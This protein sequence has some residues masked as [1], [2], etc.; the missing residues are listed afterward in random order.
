M[1]MML[2][3][4]EA[5]EAVKRRCPAETKNVTDIILHRKLKI[6]G[7]CTTTFSH[8]RPSLYRSTYTRR[9]LLRSVLNEVNVLIRTFDCLYTG[10][11][12]TTAFA[13]E[14]DCLDTGKLRTTTKRSEALS[15]RYASL[16]SVLRCQKHR[17]YPVA[18]ERFV[19][20]VSIDFD[21]KSRVWTESNGSSWFV[22]VL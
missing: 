21:M 20:H 5:E 6:V 11:L 1:A 10:K 2:T 14:Y 12:G 7:A 16:S 22:E 18:E 19:H 17:E 3:V 4:A 8:Q 13:V 9:A 15:Y